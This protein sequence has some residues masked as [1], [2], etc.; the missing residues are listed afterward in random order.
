MGADTKP[1]RKLAKTI[2]QVTYRTKYENISKQCVN[3]RSNINNMA[4]IAYT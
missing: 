1:S 3:D 2:L 4:V